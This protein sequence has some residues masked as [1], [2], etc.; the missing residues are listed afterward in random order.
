MAFRVAKTADTIYYVKRDAGTSS[1]NLLFDTVSVIIG[2]N[3][4]DSTR[5]GIFTTSDG[6][7]RIFYSRRSNNE[8]YIELAKPGAVVVVGGTI[9]VV[10]SQTVSTTSSPTV[11][12]TPP[13]SDSTAQMTQIAITAAPALTKTSSTITDFTT[14]S[15]TVACPLGTTSGDTMTFLINTKDSGGGVYLRKY[16]DTNPANGNIGATGSLDTTQFGG[17]TDVQFT[18]CAATLVKVRMG[19]TSGNVFPDGS[20]S[21]TLA[22]RV[23]IDFTPALLASMNAAG[24]DTRNLTVW[25]R[26]AATQTK[27]TQLGNSTNQAAITTGSQGVFVISATFTSFSDLMG[28]PSTGAGGGSSGGICLVT[29]YVGS[30]SP[31]CTVMRQARDMMLSSKLGRVFTSIY[32]NLN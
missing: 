2:N 6:S 27:F 17:L 7:P 13:V 10:N 29:R 8:R 14:P 23:R 31:L 30:M 3:L 19:D 16:E 4:P 12:V 21:E 9:S 11:T 25:K 28:A 15:Y 24:I 18:V 32:Y 22:I 1:T 20:I 26:D 5:L